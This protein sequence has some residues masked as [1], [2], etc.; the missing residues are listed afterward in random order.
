MQQNKSNLSCSLDDSLEPQDFDVDDICTYCGKPGADSDDHVPPRQLFSKPLQASPEPIIVRAHQSCNNGFRKDDEYFCS[1]IFRRLNLPPAALEPKQRFFEGLRK[2]KNT[3]FRK[4]LQMEEI[5]LGIRGPH[6]GVLVRSKTN[7]NR[8]ERVF[9]RYVQAVARYHFKVPYI[10][11]QSISIVHGPVDWNL[12]D[13]QGKVH[14]RFAY[15]DAFGF[16]YKLDPENPLKSAWIL[17]IYGFLF[18]LLVD[19]DK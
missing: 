17:W 4:L 3:R 1:F 19:R 6:G 5:S 18:Q 7:W 2:P 8:I 14:G 15:T 12:L 16:F 11:P 13:D 9:K 10:D